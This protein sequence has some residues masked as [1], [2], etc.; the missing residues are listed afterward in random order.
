[1]IRHVDALKSVLRDSRAATCSEPN[2]QRKVEEALLNRRAAPC[3]GVVAGAADA[4]VIA[5]AAVDR[6]VAAAA[7][8]AVVARLAVD[9][10]VPR[11]S[12]DQVVPGRSVERSGADDEVRQ[13]H[14]GT[15]RRLE[16]ARPDRAGDEPGVRG[17]N[18]VAGGERRARA[19]KTDRGER[20]H[21]ETGDVP[22]GH[23][24]SSRVRVAAV[25]VSSRASAS[26]NA[27]TS[28]DFVSPK[29][30]YR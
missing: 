3:E 30:L 4:D 22:R 29:W 23:R 11:A 14:P 2:P 25:A 26:L 15:G 21:G 27:S 12:E 8:D 20:A 19:D 9:R 28:F 16:V 7:E 18:R 13:R 1:M 6:V 17:R 24:S 5:A 10:V